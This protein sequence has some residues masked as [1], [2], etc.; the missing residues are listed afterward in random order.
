LY[1][2]HEFKDGFVIGV[3]LEKFKK[4]A[5]DI[6]TDNFNLLILEKNLCFR[7]LV[8]LVSGIVKTTNFQCISLLKS[9]YCVYERIAIQ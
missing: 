2:L 1:P 9:L 7:P 6:G 5:A 4:M 3:G 8:V